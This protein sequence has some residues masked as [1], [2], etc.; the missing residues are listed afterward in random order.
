MAKVCNGS[1]TG[2]ALVKHK[3]S[4]QPPEADFCASINI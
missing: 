3:T 1:K 4:V 2:N